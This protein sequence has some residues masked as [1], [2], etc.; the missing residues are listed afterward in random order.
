MRLNFANGY[1]DYRWVPNIGDQ[2][3]EFNTNWSLSQCSCP[4]SAKQKRFLVF[5]LITGFVF[6]LVI[7]TICY[8][9]LEQK[10]EKTTKRFLIIFAIFD[11]FEKSLTK[12]WTK[13]YGPYFD[14][15]MTVHFDVNDRLIWL[16]RIVHLHPSEPFTYIPMD[17]PHWTWLI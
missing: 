5:L 13:T 8:W 11:Y 14:T 4:V 7:I 6:P 16:W 2:I 9:R 12:C 15:T 17:H 3:L 10:V 1:N